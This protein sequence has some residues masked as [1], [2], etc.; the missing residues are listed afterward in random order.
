[1]LNKLVVED[2][3]VTNNNTFSG[4]IW[5]SKTSYIAVKGK[6]LVEFVNR[7]PEIK[8]SVPWIYGIKA[9]NTIDMD[10]LIGKVTAEYNYQWYMDS[11]NP[12]KL[13]HK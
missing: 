7:S 10:D 6:F 9:P 2:I 13:I 4:K 12:P 11:G 8:I 5:R 1:M 3:K